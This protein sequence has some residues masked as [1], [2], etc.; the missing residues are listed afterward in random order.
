M[1]FWQLLNDPEPIDRQIWLEESTL[2]VVG[3][4]DVIEAIEWARTTAAGTPFTMY[5]EVDQNPI[6][7]VR[8]YVTDPTVPGEGWERG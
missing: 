1:T 6:G 2:R 3:A 5:L 7:L 8:V 4:K